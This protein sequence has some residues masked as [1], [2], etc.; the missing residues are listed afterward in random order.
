MSSW[1]ERSIITLTT[2]IPRHIASIEAVRLS[3]G[4]GHA[5]S[6]ARGNLSPTPF[7][8]STMPCDFVGS[9]SMD[10]ASLVNGAALIL[11]HTLQ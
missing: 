5:V 8:E 3:E 6:A 11:R 7:E 4:G 2:R 10:A 9:G 1:A